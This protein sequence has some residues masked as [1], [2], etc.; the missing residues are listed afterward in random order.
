MNGTT[1]SRPR[2]LI[3]CDLPPPVTA[4]LEKAFQIDGTAENLQEALKIGARPEALL[5]SVDSRLDRHFVDQLP[6][7]IQ[8]VATYSVGTDHLDLQAL[9]ERRIRVLNTPDVLSNAVA[10]AAVFLTLGLARRAQES[11]DLVRSGAWQGW[12]PSQLIGFE[13]KGRT[14]GIIGMGRIGRAMARI[15]GALGMR[16]AYHNTRSLPAGAVAADITYHPKLSDLLGVSDVVILACPATPETIGMINRETLAQ[17]RRGA[18][19]VN[20]ARGTLINDDALIEALDNGHLGGAALDVFNNE[21][22][23]DPRY[24]DRPS[25]FM[26]PHIGSST[27]EARISMAEILRDGMLAHFAG[28]VPPNLVV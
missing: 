24:L 2:L 20:S 6:S 3:G 25:V 21:P 26:T 9:S 22:Q 10:E 4:T 5:I 27:I 1:L 28:E 12:T 18:V 19:L 16:I 23:F 14:A 11:I 15:L 17:M 13:L 7:S 8:V